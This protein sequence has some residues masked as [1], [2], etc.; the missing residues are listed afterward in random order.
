MR[1]P[2]PIDLRSIRY[3]VAIV[4]E[5][6][7]ARAA[8]K[9]KVTQPALS[10]SVQALEQTLGVKLLDRGKSGT[11]P[12]VFGRLL[13]ERG[14]GLL[15]DATA[16]TKEIALLSGA[17]AG[18]IAVGAGAY[19][20][21]ICVGPAAGRLIAQRPGLRLRITLGDWPDLTEKVLKEKLD[22]AVCDVAGAEGNSKLC[23]E[24]LPQHPGVLFCRATHPLATRKSLTLDDVREF[25]LTLT[26]L[27]ER[28]ALIVRREG[29]L[30][31]GPSRPA[32]HVDTFQLARDIVLR[33]DVIGAAIPAQILDDVRAGRAVTLPLELPWLTTHYGFIY[34]AGRTLAPSLQLFMAEVRAVENEITAKPT[35]AAAAG[36]R[37]KPRAVRKRVG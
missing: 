24:R 4:D 36:T 32:L 1:T 35:S 11:T 5:G 17:E 34:L 15:S 23:I 25:P 33:S 28:L 29:L 8:E 22:L 7:F 37:M 27:P 16:I 30:R 3:L 13:I 14:R 6:T 12:T 18:E 10:R 31:P 20:A 19:P 21:E 26:A 2:G 9:L